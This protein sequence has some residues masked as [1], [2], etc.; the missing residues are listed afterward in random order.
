MPLNAPAI[1]WRAPTTEVDGSAITYP[2][3]Y[4]LGVSE[5]ANDPRWSDPVNPDGTLALE[6]AT[7]PGE[8]N[9]DGTYQVATAD[10][11]AFD[12]DGEYF[13]RMAA[14]RRN[15]RNAVSAWSNEVVYTF[16]RPGNPEAPVL[17]DA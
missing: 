14:M 6:V 15:D 11:A 4:I 1:R 3:D 7:F 2:L 10:L 9:P 12:R 13:V 16:D 5:Q 17:L 8:L